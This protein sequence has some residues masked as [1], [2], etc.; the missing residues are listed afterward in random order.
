LILAWCVLIP[1]VWKEDNQII[2]EPEFVD[3]TEYSLKSGGVV[4]QI[5]I[6]TMPGMVRAR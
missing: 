1:Y 2:E 5:M 3:G 4:D 6:T